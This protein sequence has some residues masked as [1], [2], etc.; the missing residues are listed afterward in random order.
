MT[1]T[2]G[3]MDVE[4][5][6]TI[7]DQY[8][9]D[10]KDAGNTHIWLHH[11][12]ESL[13]HPRFDECISYAFNK[14]LKPALSINPIMLNDNI[15]ERLL[16]SNPYLLYI[17]LD[18]CDEQSF[19][20]LRGVSGKYEE[21]KQNILSF[22][23]RK[24]N[25]KSN[26]KI[27]ISAIQMRGCSQQLEEAKLFWNSQAGVD[28]FFEKPFTD[29]NGE[30]AEISEMCDVPPPPPVHETLLL[31]DHSVGWYDFT[32]LLRLQYQVPSWEH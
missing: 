21:S 11:F 32:L 30:I 23:D 4:I 8:V 10:N 1:R 22:C 14:G 9:D 2:Q 25:T 29:W 13:L 6:K 16:N 17:S 7:I 19:A 5:F 24:I 27:W 31:A 12:G 26:V 15:S 20:R 18:G 28:M 3:D